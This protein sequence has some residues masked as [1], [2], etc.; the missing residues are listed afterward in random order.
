M[1]SL[2]KLILREDVLNLGEAG[3]V[4]KTKPGFARNYLLP[5]GKAEFATEAKVQQ[6]EHQRRVIEAKRAK[7]LSDLKG[8]DKKIRSLKLEIAAKAGE[9]GKLFGSVTTQQ[10]AKLMAEK[11][12]E[13]DR[14]KIDLSEPI[15]TLGEHT[16][17]I[18]LDRQVP[19][20]I[21]LV[22]VLEE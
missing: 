10:I 16:I 14:R 2:I 21:K 15:K 4:V 17:A 7:D 20:E 1:G 12:V 11:G 6:L 22:V 8:V 5:Q 19:S 9:E 3:D 13:M 18:K